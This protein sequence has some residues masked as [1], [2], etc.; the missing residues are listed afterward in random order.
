MFKY[1]V[2]LILAPVFFSC[3][4][5]SSSP[6]D[7]VTSFI[8]AAEQHDMT[9]AWNTLS[10]EAQAFYNDI[11]EK[12][13]KS[14]KGILEHD[15]SEIT[16][17]KNKDSDYKIENSESNKVKIIT[18]KEEIVIETINIDGSFRIK[19]GNSV[20]NVIKTISLESVKKEYYF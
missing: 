18:S 15:I 2:L 1:F 9:N 10:P 20:R 4:N 3:S 6:V 5:K 12:N 14:G 16:K 19:D 8:S 13:R 7:C 17:F 11:G